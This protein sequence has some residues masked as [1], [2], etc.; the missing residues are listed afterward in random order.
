MQNKVTD[1]LRGIHE[2]EE[3]FVYQ[4]K[5]CDREIRYSANDTC[6]CHTDNGSFYCSSNRIDFAMP[7]IIENVWICETT[8]IATKTL[9]V[10]ANT[11][12]EAMLKLKSGDAEGISVNYGSIRSHRVICRDGNN[13]KS[14]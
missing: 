11:R 1:Y 14:V 8:C 6:Y 13:K 3:L 4:C 5:N 10:I 2:K 7:K 12:K 9:T